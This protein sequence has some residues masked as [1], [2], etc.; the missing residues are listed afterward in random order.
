MFRERT[1]ARYLSLVLIIFW[2]TLSLSYAAD[3]QLTLGDKVSIFSDKAYRKN[4]GRYFEA[5]GNVVIISQKDTIYGELASLDQDTMMMKIEGN[6]RFITKDMTLYGSHVDYNVTTGV[7]NVKNARI[8]TPDFNLVATHL[9]RYSQQDYL[10]EEAEFSTCK[11]CV[12][13]WS[14]YGKLIKVKMGSHVQIKHGL[15]KVKGVNVIYIPFVILPIQTKRKT[16][17]LFPRISSRLAEGLSFEQ[18]VFVAIDES[19]DMTL[20]PTFWAKRGYGGDVQYRQRFNEL[21]WVEINSRA[22]SDTLY[23]AAGQSGSEFFR[24]FTEIETHQQ[25][26][27]NL[28]THFRYTGAR[29]LDIVR[30]H[31]QFTDPRVLSSDIGFRGHVDWRR[32]FFSLGVEGNY[33]RNQLFNDPLEF[34][35]SYVQTMPRVSLSTT[36]YTL[37]QSTTPMFANITM[38]LDSSYGRFRQVTEDD[39]VFLR[40]T[41]R[42]SARPYLM[43]H[44]FTKGPFSLKSS[45]VFDQQS[46]LFS[47]DMESSAGKNASIIQTEFS[48][49]MDKIFG[50]AY[51][52]KIPVKYIPVEDLKKLRENK[53]QGLTPLSRSEKENRLIGEMPSFESDLSKENITQ[54]K[55]SYRHS[56]DFKFIH[57]Y[58]S[59]ENQY[60]NSRFIEQIKASRAGLFDFEDTIRSREYL[61]GSLIT[62]ATI[63][64]WNTVEFQW[65]N[66][67]IKKTPKSFSF[68]EDD[69]YL[70]DNFSYS[71]IGHFNVSQGYLVD[72]VDAADTDQKLTRLLLQAGYSTNKWS[73]GLSESYFHYVNENILS[74][75]ATRHFDY[76]NVF[77]SYFH[78]SFLESRINTFSVGGQFRP[79]DILGFAMVKEIDLQAKQDV[80]TIYSLDIMPHN[81]CWIL[82]LNYRESIVDSRFFFNIVFNFGDDSFHNLRN[83][84]FAVKQ[85]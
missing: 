71:Q 5:V 32:D 76:L 4:N 77:A 19:K 16:G 82:N 27:P 83:N 38:G 30:D 1:V 29:D 28:N 39:S 37:I 69:R 45:Y 49:T 17:L 36:P 58:I 14:I 24:H 72:T 47:S 60:G 59:S 62:R 80:R 7:A 42:F 26:S 65:N 8:M 9:I 53:E 31:P 20:S 13:S 66:T 67:L 40:N 55:N 81:N 61:S 51:E 68:I 3:A 57:H 56:Q 44:F 21:S 33:L 34:D 84:Y 64:L 70:R 79:T 10:A 15:A 85:L 46:Y 43:W 6:V 2:A 23:E 73:F 74:L 63:P 48:F 52:E 78:S 75:N 11:D 54:I 35:R 18:P 12:E 22:L 50:L 25:W 41:D